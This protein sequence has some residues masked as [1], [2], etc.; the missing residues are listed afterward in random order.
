MEAQEILELQRTQTHIKSDG[1]K[2]EKIGKDS[3]V[4][5]SNT[6]NTKGLVKFVLSVVYFIALVVFMTILLT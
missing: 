4:A 6:K 3:S 5:V 2:L 1:F